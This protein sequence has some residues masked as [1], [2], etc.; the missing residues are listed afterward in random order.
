MV[1]NRNKVYV[2][3]N[4]TTSKQRKALRLVVKAYVEEVGSV[5]E[6]F[7][8][9][10]PLYKGFG[11]YILSHV[12]EFGRLIKEVKQLAQSGLNLH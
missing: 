6:L 12:M 7:L 8:V 9:F 11:F 10:F 4:Y 2:H 1:P 3:V 5:L